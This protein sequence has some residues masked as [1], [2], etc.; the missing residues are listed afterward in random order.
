MERVE[1]ARR[2]LRVWVA[3]WESGRAEGRREALRASARAHG[4][5]PMFSLPFW[6]SSVGHPWRSVAAMLLLVMG[7]AVPDAAARGAA[8]S[9]RPSTSPRSSTP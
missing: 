9:E 1:E 2:S 8:K 4:Q 5:R 6:S 3:V 7:Q